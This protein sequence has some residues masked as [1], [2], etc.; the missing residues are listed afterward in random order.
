MK[1]I[2]CSPET[3]ALLQA[4]HRK[5]ATMRIELTMVGGAVI[6]GGVPHIEKLVVPQQEGSAGLTE[7]VGAPTW[8]REIAGMHPVWVHTHLCA[9]FWSGTDEGTMAKMQP[10]LLEGEK[11]K[12]CLWGI[13]VVMAEKGTYKAR[14]QMFAPWE[15]TFDDVPIMLVP[16]P[17][18]QE[19]AAAWL[20]TQAKGKI[21]EVRYQ[22]RWHEASLW[23][24]EDTEWLK[25]RGLGK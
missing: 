8:L 22:N 9:A 18:V 17:Q 3:W 16:D 10:P 19:A 23:G 20:E 12:K 15:A 13:S 2:T 25:S 24:Q 11:A 1:Y 14:V 21:K 4:L 7:T 5:S 6:R